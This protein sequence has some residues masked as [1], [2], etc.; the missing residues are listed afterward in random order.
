VWNRIRK[1]RRFIDIM[2]Y[3]PN[4]GM[5][6]AICQHGSCEFRKF[7][8]KLERLHNAGHEWDWD[9]RIS[10]DELIEAAYN[11]FTGCG[12]VHDCRTTIEKIP[13]GLQA[14]EFRATKPEQ[15]RTSMPLVPRAC[16]G[17]RATRPRDHHGETGSRD[18]RRKARLSQNP[19]FLNVPPKKGILAIFLQNAGGERFS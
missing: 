6:C 15:Q 3:L 2:K 12:I 13:G 8:I 5:G 17:T 10:I 1:Q 19:R 11:I 7:L 9:R 4:P 14:S 18:R 16:E